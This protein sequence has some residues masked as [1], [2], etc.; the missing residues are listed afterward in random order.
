MTILK[1]K[2]LKKNERKNISGLIFEY[3]ARVRGE[4]CI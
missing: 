4:N 3:E 2:Q 1:D